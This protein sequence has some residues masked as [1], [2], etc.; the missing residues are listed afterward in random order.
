MDDVTQ[1]ILDRLDDVRDSVDRLADHV[2][3][4]NGRVGRLE[5]WRAGLEAVANTRSWR[6]PAA[7]GL[8][9]AVVAG[10]VIAIVTAAIT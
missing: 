1:I 8:A 3:V 2:A 10:V 5:L 7:F 4:Q 6:W 9:A